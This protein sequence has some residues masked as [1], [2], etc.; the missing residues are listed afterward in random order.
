MSTYHTPVLLQEVILGLQVTAGKRYIDATLGGGGHTKAIL[1]MGADVLA[2]D[3]D[4]EAIAENNHLESPHC[5]IV[6]GNFR[7]IESIAK[8]N[9]WTEIDGVLLDLGVSSHQL[10]T[11]TRGF[12]F[13]FPDAPLDM[14]FGNKAKETAGDLIHTLS[15]EEL[16]RIFT[17]FGEEERGEEIAQIIVKQRKQKEIRTVG[18][19][20]EVISHVTHKESGDTTARIF[21]ALRIAVNDELQSLTDG[22]AGALRITKNG[23]RIAVISFHSLEDRIV[24]QFFLRPGI[25]CVTKKPIIASE[26]ERKQNSRSRSAKLRI[27]QKNI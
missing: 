23:G 18:D 20:K 5:R 12:S 19:L 24:K 6:E 10:D 3:E 25:T 2:I 9:A 22:L 27:G 11:P 4:I 26:E 1:A 7:N 13:R 8:A 21:Q 16:T 17:V 15:K 14:R